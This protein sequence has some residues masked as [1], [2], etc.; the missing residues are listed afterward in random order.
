MHLVRTEPHSISVASDLIRSHRQ[1]IE[2]FSLRLAQSL[3]S[4]LTKECESASEEET[5][6]AIFIG[7]LA[8]DLADESRFIADLL[9][10][11]DDYPSKSLFVRALRISLNQSYV[12]FRAEMSAVHDVA[13]DKWRIRSVS[14]ALAK[15]RIFRVVQPGEPTRLAV[16]QHL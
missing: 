13:L 7:K 5:R 8:A 2:R 14:T 3:R 6:V 1:E 15:C 11:S 16:A 4:L 9:P 12:A 10:A